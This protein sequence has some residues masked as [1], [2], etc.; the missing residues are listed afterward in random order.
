MV[1]CRHVKMMTDLMN[2]ERVS[3]RI[4][5][6]RIEFRRSL[7]VNGHCQTDYEIIRGLTGWLP[8]LKGQS[9]FKYE[10]DR[11]IVCTASIFVQA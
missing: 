5:S 7:A 4:M 10:E 9:I 6:E 2:E 1:S 3:K 11:R 8:L